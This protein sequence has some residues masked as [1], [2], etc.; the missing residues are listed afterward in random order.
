MYKKYL[1]RMCH[2][3]ISYFKKGC[4]DEFMPNKHDADQRK[5]IRFAVF[6]I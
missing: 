2:T 3:I 5:K 1:D 6:D 4:S